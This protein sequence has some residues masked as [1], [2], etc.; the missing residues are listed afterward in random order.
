M[1]EH[2]PAII[3]P[4]KAGYKL[5]LRNMKVRKLYDRYKAWKGISYCIALSDAQRHEF[6]KYALSRFAHEYEQAYGEKFIYPGHDH[7]R[8]MM[9]ELI[10]SMEEL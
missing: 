7:T 2:E 9:N 1:A 8:H 6:E 5:N 4:N 3:L 10:N